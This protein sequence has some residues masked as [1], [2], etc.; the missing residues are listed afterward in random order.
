MGRTWAFCYSSVFSYCYNIFFITIIITIIT[1][2]TLI[3]ILTIVILSI[4]T[5]A[6]TFLKGGHAEAW[7]K[8]VYLRLRAYSFRFRAFGCR[9]Y[10]T[11]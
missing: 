1:I 9:S 6:V 2:T 8:A 11:V 7:G 3:T 4:I 5:I 10:S